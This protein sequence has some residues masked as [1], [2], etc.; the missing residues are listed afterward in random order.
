M[1]V[2]KK[3]MEMLATVLVFSGSMLATVLVLYSRMD[4]VIAAVLS[5]RDMSKSKGGAKSRSP[6]VLFR[7]VTL[8]YLW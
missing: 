1:F 2:R 7:S 8:W 5:S 3:P 6:S 4:L